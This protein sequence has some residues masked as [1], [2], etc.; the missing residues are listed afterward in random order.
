MGEGGGMGKSIL[1][2]FLAAALI[3]IL[4]VVLSGGAIG[5][6]GGKWRH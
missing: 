5:M 2:I 1:T 4:D 6:G 3:L